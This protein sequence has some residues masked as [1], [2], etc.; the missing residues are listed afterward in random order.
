MTYIKKSISVFLCFVMLITA[1]SSLTL[2]ASADTSGGDWYDTIKVTT[3]ANY[4]YPGAS[5]ITLTQQKQTVTYKSCFSRKTKTD[6]GY[7]GYYSID[8]YEGKNRLPVTKTWDGGKSYKIKL[9][10]NR[11]YTIGVSYNA[12]ETLKNAKNKIGYTKQKVDR[13]WWRVSS[14]WKISSCK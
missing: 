11:T 8:I 5:S 13:P 6:K 14:K 7:F 2:T 1:I 3:K 12:K 10:P 4:W 9:D